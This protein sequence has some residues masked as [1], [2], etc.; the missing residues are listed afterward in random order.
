MCDSSSDSDFA[1]GAPAGGAP[2][3][4]VPAGGSSASP[5]FEQTPRSLLIGAAL[6]II[7]GVLWG[8][9]A[10]VSKLLMANY[11]ADP[12]WIACVREVIAGTM[13]LVCAAIKEPKLLH[14]LARDRRS[15]PK[16]LASS[17]AC[18]L[19]VQVSYLCAIDWT[20]SGTATVLQTLNLLFVLAYVCIRG[21]RWPSVRESIGVALAF[22]G[23]TLIATGGDLSTLTLPLPGLIWGLLDALGTC[24]LSIMP[25]KLIARWGNLAVN[26]VMFLISG[27]ILTPFVRPWQ[28]VPQ[29]DW[30][31]ILLMVFTVV[32]GTFGAFWLFLAGVMRVGAMRGTMLG[33][34]EP[35]AATVSGVVWAGSVFSSTDLVGFAMIIIM[36]FL[37]R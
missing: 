2:A 6:V 5:S 36:V 11:H 12:L 14:G 34:S 21:R 28:N 27:I 19:L 8:I 24:A 20:N 13:F 7:G 10:T 9:N 29:F 17:L 37:V 23:T 1:G 15:Y 22:V 4:G 25:T 18:V 35:I 3:G 26:G 31:G 16:L 30:L 32:G 33:T